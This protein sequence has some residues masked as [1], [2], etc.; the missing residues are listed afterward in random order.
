MINFVDVVD[1][2]GIKLPQDDLELRDIPPQIASRSEAEAI[3]SLGEG[4][5]AAS[6]TIFGTSFAMNVA[7]GGGLN[8]LWSAING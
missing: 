1:K 4:V 3:Q 2:D 6:T 5:V 7:L 8:Q